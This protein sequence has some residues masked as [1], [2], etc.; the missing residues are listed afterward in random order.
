[1]VGALANVANAVQTV[2]TVASSWS[3]MLLAI[4]LCRGQ[5]YDVAQ[6]AR[7]IFYKERFAD[8]PALVEDR[9]GP[10]AP[11]VAHKWGADDS[12]DNLTKERRA[13]GQTI[14][15]ALKQ[16][17]GADKSL[18]LP[19]PEA[20]LLSALIRWCDGID[21][22]QP[23]DDL[24]AKLCARG[25]GRRALLRMQRQ[26]RSKACLSSRDSRYSVFARRSQGRW[27]A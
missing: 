9:P 25:C 18:L 23:A 21:R 27:V 11:A 16:Q 5:L 19:S 14:E 10:L 22:A 6:K 3:Q 12:P 24:T 1:M 17:R 2:V 13:F 20:H 4:Q 7:C 26:L 8:I 15:M